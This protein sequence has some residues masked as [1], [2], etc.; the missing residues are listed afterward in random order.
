MDAVDL[1]ILGLI[2]SECRRSAGELAHRVGLSVSAAR[3]RLRRLEAVGTVRAHRALLDPHRLGLDLCAF[4]LVELEPRA[5][6]LA[7]AE[8]VRL[9]PVVQEAYRVTGAHSWLLKVRV[10]NSPALHH[11]IGTHLKRQFGAIRVTTMVA[12]EVVK[13]TTELPLPGSDCWPPNHAAQRMPEA[14]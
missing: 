1:H 13:E 12:F 11:L 9:L 7:F 4:L 10:R 3:D 2:Q 14:S 5:D 6:D 8:E